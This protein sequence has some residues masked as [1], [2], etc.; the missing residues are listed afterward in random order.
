MMRQQHAELWGEKVCLTDITEADIAEITRWYSDSFFRRFY[1]SPAALPR[2]EEETRRWILEQ[3]SE[4][5]TCF[6]AIRLRDAD[7]IIGL[8]SIAG[9]V[10][11]MGWLGVGIGTDLHRGKGYGREAIKL[12]LDYAFLELRLQQIQLLVY[13]FNHTAIALYQK[14]GFKSEGVYRSDMVYEKEVYNTLLFSLS[15]ARWKLRSFL[16]G[17]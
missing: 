13:D 2:S 9:I 11:G 4:S 17:G 15:R 6:F 8:I 10:D 14:M 3:R 1:E 12:M 5:N 16:N 7:T